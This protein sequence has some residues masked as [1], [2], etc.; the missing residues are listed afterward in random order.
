M[1]VKNYLNRKRR[2]KKHSFFADTKL[3]VDQT[4]RKIATKINKPLFISQNIFRSQIDPNPSSKET[5]YINIGLLRK[6]IGP[7]NSEF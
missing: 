5:R 2:M 4:E 1:T 6:P 3:Q 7:I